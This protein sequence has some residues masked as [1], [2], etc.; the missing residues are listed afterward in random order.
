MKTLIIKL[1]ATG[2]VVRTTTLLRRLEG[3]VTWLTDPLNRV[4]LDGVSDRLQCITWPE[5][6]ALAG[7]SFDLVVNL[8]DAAEVAEFAST[9]AAAQTFGAVMGADGRV[10]YT[11][12]ASAWFDMSLV[13][14]FGRRRADELKLANR[15]SYQELIFEGLGWSFAGETYVLP[16][17]RSTSLAGDVALAPTAGPVWP[18]KNWAHYPALKRALEERGLRVNELPRRAH[19]LEHLGDVRNHRCLVGGDSLPMH[20]ALGLGVP[21]VTIF[22]CTSPW[23]IYDYGLQT[24]IVSPL[25]ADYFYSRESDERARAA[26]PLETVVEAVIRCLTGA[27]RR[28]AAACD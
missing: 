18:N 1:N 13:S 3:H 24:K 23:E 20:I 15:R 4:L 11:D 26:I 22:N 2:D 14:R 28:V 12:S 17:V 7:S 6:T 9:I 21:C 19:L 5:K 25:L 10:T 8:E 16:S 27:P